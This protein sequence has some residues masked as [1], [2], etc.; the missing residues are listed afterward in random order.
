MKLSSTGR[1]F[2]FFMPKLWAKNVMRPNLWT[3]GFDLGV[4]VSRTNTKERL[5]KSESPE[6]QNTM[7]FEVMQECFIADHDSKR[8]HQHF[9]INA[10][11]RESNPFGKTRLVL[12]SQVRACSACPST[13][14]R[15][16]EGQAWHGLTRNAVPKSFFLCCWG[17]CT[18]YAYLCLVVSGNS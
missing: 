12:L 9:T 13:E 1:L 14:E 18:T 7:W 2:R 10:V 5:V 11:L 3:F 6:H 15:R 17:Y 4:L 16:V 8:K